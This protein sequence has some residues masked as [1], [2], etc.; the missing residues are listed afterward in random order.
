MPINVELGCFAAYSDAFESQYPDFSEYSDEKLR[1]TYPK[2]SSGQRK[3]WQDMN[4]DEI[5]LVLKGYGRFFAFLINEKGTRVE[6]LDLGNETNYGF[7]GIMMPLKSAVSKATS[8]KFSSTYLMKNF[9]SEYLAKN[10]WSYNGKMF[11]SLK[12]GILKIYPEAKFSSHISI[13][14]WGPSYTVKYFKTL[15]ENGYKVDQ[16]GISYYPNA[17]NVVIDKIAQIKQIV[18]AC[19]KELNL[20]V[21]L[22]EYGYANETGLASGTFSS[23]NNKVHGYELNDEDG[24]RFLSELIKWGKNNGMAGI[25]PWACELDWANPWFDFDSNSKT[26]KAKTLLFN[27]LKESV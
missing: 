24:A 25:R 1:I 10:I 16:A 5:C 2:D 27:A 22:A 12:E 4:I 13:V 8:K 26:A 6:Y 9:G 21:M 17:T 3:K 14:T 20:N 23:W 15:E 18:L 7:G 11:A 19:N